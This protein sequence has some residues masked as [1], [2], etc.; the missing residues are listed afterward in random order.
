MLA[1][2]FHKPAVATIGSTPGKKFT[3]KPRVPIRPENHLATIPV[4]RR[5]CFYLRRIRHHHHLRILHRFRFLFRHILQISRGRPTPKIIPTHQHRSTPSPTT[6][7]H[8]R[9]VKKPH[10]L[11]QQLH[12]ATLGARR[13]S[14]HIHLALNNGRILRIDLHPAT[15][16]TLLPTRSRNDR[17]R[18]GG[19]V[20]SRYIDLPTRGHGIIS[21]VLGVHF[22]CIDYIAQ[23]TIQPN[24]P[25]HIRHHRLRPNRSAVPDR[26][27]VNVSRG[28]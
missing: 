7:I 25:V 20:L 24:R 3:I 15:I 16:P 6:R 1:R 11:T 10:P 27:G 28:V 26:Q 17:F 19:D 12:L 9:P 14:C 8:H 18:R 22:A 4:H 13:S 2:S 5:I 23:P 21:G